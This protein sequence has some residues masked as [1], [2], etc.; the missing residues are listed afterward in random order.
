MAWKKIWNFQLL[1]IGFKHEL[2]NSKPR[3]VK[4]YTSREIPLKMRLHS[5]LWCKCFRTKKNY[6]KALVYEYLEIEETG[7][8][9]EISK[10]LSHSDRE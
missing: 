2:D 5:P 3:R 4:S 10:C 6:I 8:K 7:E 9:I 1:L